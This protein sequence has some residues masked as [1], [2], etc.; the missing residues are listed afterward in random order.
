MQIGYVRHNDD[1]S[2]QAQLMRAVGDFE[3]KLDVV[4]PDEWCWVTWENP[5]R[6]RLTVKSA[7]A[8]ELLKDIQKKFFRGFGMHEIQKQDGYVSAAFRFDPQHP[9]AVI[10]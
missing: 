10:G 3:R 8:E 1:A 6:I 2:N 4:G 7:R 5:L 9:L